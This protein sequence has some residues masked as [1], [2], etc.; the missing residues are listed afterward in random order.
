EQFEEIAH[1][2]EQQSVAGLGL[3]PMVLRHHRGLGVGAGHH[4][5]VVTAK[6]APSEGDSGMKVPLRAPRQEREAAWKATSNSRTRK[7]S[8]FTPAAR[9][10]RS[11]ISPPHTVRR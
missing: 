2:V 3:Q 8:T 5:Q 4:V 1:A 7:R 11:Q 10:A 6:R 9:R